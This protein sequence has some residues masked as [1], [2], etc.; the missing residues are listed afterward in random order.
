MKK[1][2]LVPAV[3]NGKI[4]S[5]ARE[6]LKGRFLLC[7]FIAFALIISSIIAN[8]ASEILNGAVK[9]LFAGV[10]AVLFETI[11]M[12]AYTKYCGK[13]SDAEE[14]PAFFE[15]VPFVFE[16]LVRMTLATWLASLIIFLKLLLIVPGI[17]AM[18]DYAMVG[19]VL[20]DDREVGVSDALKIS[21]RLMYGHRWQFL[22]ISMRFFGL[23]ILC[24]F[25]LGIGYFWLIPYMITSYWK[26]YRS[27]TPQPDTPEEAE[28]SFVSTASPVSPVWRILIVIILVLFAAVEEYVNE[29]KAE[30]LA[31]D[32]DKALNSQTK[33]SQ[34]SETPKVNNKPEAHQ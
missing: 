18:L 14:N 15:C 28:L 29:K 20:L 30:R 3:E 32:I 24:I 21:K 2:V 5:S 6:S 4:T 8:V 22:C 33:A 1:T 7:A 16:R 9:Y 23:G 10:F 31:K 34:S 26:F 19:L 11:G 17:L 25:T 12:A 13:I 27:I